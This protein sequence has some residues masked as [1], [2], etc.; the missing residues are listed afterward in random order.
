MPVSPSRIDVHCHAVPAVYRQAMDGASVPGLN[1]RLPDWSPEHALELMDRHGIAAA[2]TSIS[3]P[4]VHLGDDR[5]A[6]LLARQCNEAAAD[7]IARWPRRF[8]A[9]ATLPLPDLAGAIAEA[10]YALDV[11]KLDGIGLFTSYQRDHIGHPRFDP[12]LELLDAKGAVVLVHPTAHP[13]G[14]ELNLG[15]PPFLMEYPFDTTRAAANLILQGK[16]DRYPNIRYILSHAGG[17]LPFL[18]WRIA[19]V[20][21]SLLTE[22]Q[23]RK[24]YPLPFVEAHEGHCSAELFMGKLRGFWYDTANAAGPEMFAALEHVTAPDRLLFGSDWPYVPQA[25]LASTIRSVD[26]SFPAPARRQ[27]V[28]HDNAAAL[29]PRLA[30][31]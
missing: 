30:A 20:T 18:A 17:T 1:V 25:Q 31:V 7:S 6:R 14:R 26:D 23:M 10:A 2:V 22:P 28:N 24:R 3:V 5:K 15:V 19:E 27:A 21:A 13:A 11:L 16:I 12:L 4:G 8:G 29:F 9:F